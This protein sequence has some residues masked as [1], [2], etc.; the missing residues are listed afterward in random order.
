MCDVTQK[1]EYDPRCLS[2]LCVL[3]GMRVRVTAR[4]MRKSA[5]GFSTS[6]ASN[7]CSSCSVISFSPFLLL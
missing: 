6:F 2:F 1:R 4:L 5:P 7:Y 3:L